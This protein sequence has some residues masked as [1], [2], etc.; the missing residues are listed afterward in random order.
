MSDNLIS[1]M[2]V[3]TEKL[4]VSK[5]QDVL[6]EAIEDYKD[7][8]GK[9]WKYDIEIIDSYEEDGITKVAY[10]VNHKGKGFFNQKDGDEK[11]TLELVKS[12]RKWYINKL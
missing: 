7:K 8:Y 10:K 4:A 12:G 1:E 5:M 6:D 2:N 11:G 3:A 9:K